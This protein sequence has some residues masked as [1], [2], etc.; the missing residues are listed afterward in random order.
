MKGVQ[1]SKVRSRVALLS[2]G[3][4]LILVSAGPAYSQA[5]AQAPVPMNAPQLADPAEADQDAPATSDAHVEDIVV[6]GTLLRGVAPVGTNVIGVDREQIRATGATSTND[7]LSRIPQISSNFNRVAVSSTNDPG[8]TISRPNIRNLG[9]SG[10]NT[11]LVLVDGHRIVGAGVLQTTP[12]PDVVPPGII[13]RVEI[14]PDGGSSIYGSDA[15]GGVINFITRKR[16]DGLEL[17]GR[18]GFADDYYQYDI[19]ATAGKDWGFGSLYASYVFTKHDAILGLDRDFVRQI[20]PN[21]AC[22]PGT[23]TVGTVGSPTAVSYALP[24]R[25]AN[26]T[27]QCDVSDN[28]SIVPAERRHSAF[29]GFNQDLNDAISVDVRAFYTNRVTNP[30]VDQFRSSVTITA[31][32]PFFVPIG[33]ATS[34]TVAFSYAPVF[35]PS[36]IS[37]TKLNEWGVTPSFSAKLGGGWQLR[38][39]GNY[40]RSSTSLRNPALNPTLQTVALGAT[41]TGA[42]LNPYDPTQTNGPVLAGIRNFE[43]YGKS[44]QE[45]G[46][47]R[48]ILDGSLFTLP[49]G[50]VRVATGGEI[51]W[52]SYK[53]GQG[54]RV[55]NNP[56]GLARGRG[57][58]TGKSLFG[59]LA[60]P[61]FGSGNGFAGMR[62]LT[63]AASGRYDHYSDFGSTFNPKVGVTWRPLEGL[64]IRG[65]YGTSFNAPSLADTGAAI[66]QVTVAP[67]LVLN[68]LAGASATNPAS[69]PISAL[70]SIILVTGGNPNLQP[71]EA[72]T[73]SAG[74]DLNPGAI[75]GL[76]ISGTYWKVKFRN[77]ISIA[78]GPNLFAPGLESFYVLNPTQAQTTT[79]AGSGQV[80]GAF[81]NGRGIVPATTV[82]GVFSS[83]LRPYLLADLRRNNLGEVNTDGLD[84]NARYVRSTGFGSLNVGASGSYILNRDARTT[85]TAPLVDVL[86]TD[87]SRLNLSA[88]AG[89]NVKAFSAQAT[90]YHTAGYELGTAA[91]AQTRV[92]SYNVVDLVLTYDL[93]GKGILRDLSLS[94]NVNNLF[95]QDP[96]FFNSGFGYANGST[97]GRLI[98]FGIRKKF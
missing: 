35:G 40:G 48:L 52:E 18:Y 86:A 56:D 96:P 63:L 31:A 51:V 21:T 82:E 79:I 36:N 25:V 73:Y 19:N 27:A 69:P 91:G 43:T 61:I 2:G 53:L 45:L 26:T 44:I 94:L 80:T 77:Q 90:L 50:D 84:F 47:G 54:T 10:S 41:T 28:A 4:A 85:A 7:V 87:A 93:T 38:A 11:T 68:T 14:V 88:S 62:S 6:T 81:F 34:Q 60:I 89:A 24:G 98:Q 72:T 46:N 5:T 8:T 78:F 67:L 1:A 83:P 37:T 20:T 32:N 12:D 9:A 65:N 17:N 64:S 13:E 75:P 57:E 49:G 74:F 55:V 30:S 33:T 97:L 23:V 15:I 95:D 58:R 70:Q 92:G 22:A 71:Q 39:M 3:A 59:E 42:A 76:S 66:S 16:F 29:A